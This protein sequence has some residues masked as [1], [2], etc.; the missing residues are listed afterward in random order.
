MMAEN[1]WQETFA[2]VGEQWN[3]S[4]TLVE[5]LERFTCNVYSKKCTTTNIN[6][7]RYS[8]FCAKKGDIDSH[9]LPPCK[10]TLHKHMLRANYQAAIWQRSLEQFPEVPNPTGHGWKIESQDG[11]DVLAVD[12]MN[13]KPAPQALIDLL[14]CTCRRECKMPQCDCMRNALKCTDMCTLTECSNW[15]TADAE[16]EDDENSDCDDDLDDD[17][18]G[19]GEDDDEV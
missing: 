13:G 8:L 10:D 7:L 4:D 14:A 1:D 17:I 16:S 19:E 18:Y 12:W 9:Q 5:K 6:D 2:S 15:T 11:Q 3:M